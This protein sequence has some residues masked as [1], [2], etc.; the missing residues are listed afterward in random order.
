MQGDVREIKEM[1]P[2]I[3]TLHRYSVSSDQQVLYSRRVFLKI[4][5][6]PVTKNKSPHVSSSPLLHK[7]RRKRGLWLL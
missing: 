2:L 1:E 6:I 7:P 5:T 4:N 3:E